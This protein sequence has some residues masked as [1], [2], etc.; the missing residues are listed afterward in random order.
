ME[1]GKEKNRRFERKPN[2]EMHAKLSRDGRYWI[3]KRIE[4]WILP[5]RYMDVITQNHTA[6]ANGADVPKVESKPQKKGK[7][8]ADSNGQGN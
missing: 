2:F 5:R 1:N 8:N 7:R 3:I 4:T 6:E